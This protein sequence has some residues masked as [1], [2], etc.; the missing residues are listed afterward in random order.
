MAVGEKKKHSHNFKR[1]IVHFNNGFPPLRKTPLCCRLAGKASYQKG[2]QLLH[3]KALFLTS[4][5]KEK[6]G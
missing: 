3:G 2:S 5:V 6:V 4:F 1:T